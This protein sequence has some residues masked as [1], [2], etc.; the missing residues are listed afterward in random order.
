MKK[1]LW[2]F[3][4]FTFLLNITFAN[5]WDIYSINKSKTYVKEY[6]FV[7]SKLVWELKKWYIVKDLWEDING[8]K[9]VM[10]TDWKIWYLLNNN[11][12]ENMLSS[13]KNIMKCLKNFIYFFVKI[14]AF[15]KIK[16]YLNII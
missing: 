3:L 2:I 8:W 7:Y 13:K 15:N 14:N 4:L 10:L 12:G 1:I 6:P 16:W 5:F 9:K 11:I